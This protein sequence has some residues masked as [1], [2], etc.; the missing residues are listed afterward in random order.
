M[1]LTQ[2]DGPVTYPVAVEEAKANG[3][4]GYSS[5]DALIAGYIAAATA[6]VE[7]MTGRAFAVQ[8][9]TAQLDA[10]EDEIVIPMGPATVTLIRYL[11]ADGAVQTVEDGA[12]VVDGSGADCRI[13]PVTAWPAAQKTYNA[14]TIEFAVGSGDVPP[15]IKQAILLLVQ[16]WFENRSA[17][18]EL[19]QMPLAVEWLI[20]MHRRMWV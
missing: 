8:Y 6:A 14:I 18:T 4:I 11:D 13:A 12:Y 17:L 3:R 1:I 9:W 15:Q 7:Q 19:R 16:Y 10:W 5:E 20:G 2:T